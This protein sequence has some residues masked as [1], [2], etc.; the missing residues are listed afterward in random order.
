MWHHTFMWHI[1]LYIDIFGSYI[2]RV[3]RVMYTSIILATLNSSLLFTTQQGEELRILRDATSTVLS[4]NPPPHSS[5]SRLMPLLY[6]EPE[7]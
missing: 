1:V 7:W 4:N 6:L 5:I 2:R 3:A